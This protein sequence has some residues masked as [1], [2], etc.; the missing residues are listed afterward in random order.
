MTNAA[1]A[2]ADDGKQTDYAAILPSAAAAG[3]QETCGKQNL[4]CC[5]AVQDGLSSETP[6]SEA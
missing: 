2:A 3:K 4:V 5:G 6:N 1:A